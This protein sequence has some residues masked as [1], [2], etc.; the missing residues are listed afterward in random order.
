MSAFPMMAKLHAVPTVPK[1]NTPADKVKRRVR[2]SARDWPACPEGHRETVV[3]QIGNV[4]N[5]LCVV[6]LMAGR[7]VV[8]E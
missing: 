6:C 8:V 5:K 7:R 3:A 2:K 4:R 1:P